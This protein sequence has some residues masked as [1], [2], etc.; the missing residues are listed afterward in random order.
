MQLSH[1]MQPYILIINF[2]VDYEAEN[3]PELPRFGKYKSVELRSNKKSQETLKPNLTQ[4]VSRDHTP[5]DRYRD[6]SPG[7]VQIYTPNIL[8]PSFT[9]APMF[10]NV[11]SKQ[12]NK[13]NAE[14]ISHKYR[15]EPHINENKKNAY[16]MRQ[17]KDPNQSVAYSR[18]SKKRSQRHRKIDT[19]NYIVKSLNT[20]KY[21]TVSN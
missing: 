10:Q 3:Y 6:Y 17:N 13:Y 8:Y 14:D 7:D 21:T 5:T 19:S 9:S 15:I 16:H 4:Q 20:S 1:I 2:I 18:N 11:K 12:S